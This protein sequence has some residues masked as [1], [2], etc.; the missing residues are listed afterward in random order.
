[1][2][3]FRHVLL[4]ILLLTQGK[5]LAQPMATDE[6]PS[7]PTNSAVLG[8]SILG[9]PTLRFSTID[10]YINGVTVDHTT[11]SLSVSLGLTWSLQVRATDDLRYQNQSIPISAISVRATNIGNRPEVILSTANQT[12]ASGLA[13]LPISLGTTF[14]YRAQ[15]DAFLKPG[16]NYTTTLVFS[17]TAL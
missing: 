3:W 9:S 11:L 2:N 5:L 8:L 16:G 10:D 13:N 4:T 1:M 15:G 7:P 14:R 17:F 12:V 6:P